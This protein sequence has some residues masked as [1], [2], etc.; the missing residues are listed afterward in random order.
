MTLQAFV[1]RPLSVADALCRGEAGGSYR[2]AYLI[3]SGVMSGLSAH[4]WPGDGRDR[5]RFV[6]AWVRFGSPNAARTSLPLLVDRL[7]RDRAAD[8]ERL[9]GLRP[10]MLG[11]GYDCRIVTGDDI[12]AS[13][14]EVLARCPSLERRRVRRFSYPVIF[15]EQVRSQMVHEYRLGDRATAYPMT[16][17]EDAGVSYSNSLREM[18]HGDGVYDLT[19]REV[20]FPVDWLIS[21]T[22]Q[23]ARGIDTVAPD[24][25]LAPPDVWWL[26][27]NAPYG[28]TGA[29]SIVAER[30]AT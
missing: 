25:G 10:E 28:D 8:A 4:L 16:R 19:T 14:E 3:I 2:E 23:I 29:P 6:E 21:L 22:R 30:P 1:E 9:E 15:Y 26:H 20:H 18:R 11:P 12:D 27:D 7:Y 5:A 24:G 13:E 17:H